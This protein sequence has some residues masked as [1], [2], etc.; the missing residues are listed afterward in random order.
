M[1]LK[2]APETVRL[3]RMAR[4]YAAGELAEADYRRAR[5]DIID[6]FSTAARTDDTT[7]PRWP[8][9][10]TLRRLEIDM[11][12][13]GVAHEAHTGADPVKRWLWLLVLAGA[14]IAALL[15]LPQ[16]YGA[17]LELPPVSQREPDPSSSPRL[18]VRQVQVEWGADSQLRMPL[19]A[20][21]ARADQAL[22][23][24]RIRNVPGPHGFTASELEELARYLNVLG[25]HQDD[26]P[27]DVADARDLGALIRDQKARRGISVAELEQVAGEVQAELRE[28]GYFLAVAYLPAQRLSD[29]MVRIEVLPGRLGDIVIEGSELGLATGA[30]SDLLGQPI[31]L[32]G[33]TSRL[34]ALNA[35]PGVTAQAS[36]GP[37]LEVGDTRLRLDVAERRRWVAAATVDNHGDDATGE[38]QFGLSASWLSPRGVGDRLNVG[39]LVTADPGN[40]RYGYLQYEMPLRAGYRL[41]ASIG[42]NDFTWDDAAGLDGRGMF[43]DLAARRSLV[44]GRGAGLALVFAA[45]RHDLEWDGGIDQQVTLGGVGLLAHRVWD[46]PRIAADL[47]ANVSLG[48]I[49]GDRFAQQDS[50]FWLLELEA[51]AWMPVSLPLLPDEQKLR[52]RL[53]GQWSDSL[54]PAT[55]R[56]AL[57]GRY[58][59]RGFDRSAF[60]ADRAVLLGVEARAPVQFGELLL[61]SETAYG[62]DLAADDGRWGHLSTLGVGWEAQLLPGLESR[63]SWAIPVTTRGTGGIDGDDSRV[64]WSLRYEH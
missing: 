63:L 28:Q 22:E 10:Q 15:G 9:D 47:A 27:L 17:M 24:I 19:A 57:G 38:Q 62:D 11:S 3:R 20:L 48:R 7:Q 55:R 53:A 42:N 8:A 18:P 4:A 50:D 51:D 43:F 26:R 21:Q 23:E 64:Y 12:A 2:L 31:T 13:S 56:F 52:V 36:F 46:R 33:V 16:S 32:S 54:L 41:A 61:F 37:G 44:Q 58:R 40:Q 39:A 49:D 5:R 59:V 25:V 14:L 34:Q 1:F 45:G 29:G 60:L 6:N 35:L 30:F